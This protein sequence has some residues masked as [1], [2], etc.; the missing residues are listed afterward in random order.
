MNK[1]LVLLT[2]LFMQCAFAQ[3]AAIRK[4]VDTFFEG[5]HKADTLKMQS[6]CS[7]KLVLH[8]VYEKGGNNVL[9]AEDIKNFYKSI[10][11][12]PPGFQI[13]ERL[14]SFE[15]TSHGLMANAWAPYEFYING[16]LSHS[17]VNSFS[18]YN[19]NG[20]WKITYIIDTRK[21]P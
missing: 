16:K 11:E 19:D 9:I 17:G 10:A 2:S 13:Y 5:L 14:L 21:K 8:T 18:L 6:I 15:V 12:L 1:L 20:L 3:D 7:D 4:T